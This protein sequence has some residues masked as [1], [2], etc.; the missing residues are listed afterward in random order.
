MICGGY[1]VVDKGEKLYNIKLAGPYSWG[2]S[3]FG[4]ALASH[5]RGTGFDSLNLHFHEGQP[6]QPGVFFWW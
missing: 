1:P 2:F 6:P 5:A 3:S 4:R